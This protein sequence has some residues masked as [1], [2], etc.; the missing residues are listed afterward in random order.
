MKRQ[1]IIDA[2]EVMVYEG[3][4]LGDYEN[5]FKFLGL[6]LHISEVEESY[7]TYEVPAEDEVGITA[8]TIIE[9]FRIVSCKVVRTDFGHED[10]RQGW[11]E[12]LICKL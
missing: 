7:T 12:D 4:S 11:I 10:E 3:E 2:L 9:N 8:H 6:N 5:E 1:H